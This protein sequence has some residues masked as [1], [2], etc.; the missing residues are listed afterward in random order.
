MAHSA[1]LVTAGTALIA[2]CYGLARFTYGL[3]S[4]DFAAEFALSPAMSGVL[5][6]GSY[7]GYCV[8]IV[9]AT[10][11]T[12][13][14]GARR[15]AVLAGATA[16]VGIAT[17]AASS[18]AAMLAV[19]ILVA[20]SSTGI[21][22]PPMAAAVARWISQR[23]RDQAQTLV[24]A[25]TGIGVLLS[26]PI[27]LALRSDWRSAWAIFAVLSALVT[28]AVWRYVP[29]G[30]HAPEGHRSPGNWPPGSVRLLVCSAA[31]GLASIAVW[32]LG[33]QVISE[34]GGTP[35]VSA[36]VWTVLGGA[37]LV[38]AVSGPLVGRLGIARAWQLGMVVMGAA[39]TAFAVF[40]QLPVV[41]VAAAFAFGAAY[42]A[43]TGVLLV[44]ATRLFPE[45]VAF[46]VGSAFL[47]V[48]AG[49]AAGSTLAGS[50]VQMLSITTVFIIC[51]AIALAGAAVGHRL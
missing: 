41:T 35:L 36:L 32:T 19:G 44:W 25:G 1:A 31:L 4:P 37:G 16:T 6:S 21:A 29:A 27:A 8:A 40:A 5:G 34:Q 49:Q 50:G 11:L 23:R 12:P 18:S 2:S 45:R 48:A 30:V 9:V 42:I 33:R 3:F 10:V 47:V 17:V 15:V 43:L 24:N 46:G 20:G 28:V 14:W 13:R 22:S 7:V 51:T 38:G 39:T 26:G